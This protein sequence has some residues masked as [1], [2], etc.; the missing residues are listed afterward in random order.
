MFAEEKDDRWHYVYKGDLVVLNDLAEALDVE[1][2][3]YHNHKP[4]VKALMN[5]TGETWS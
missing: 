1:F 5:E 2:R 4:A 3:H